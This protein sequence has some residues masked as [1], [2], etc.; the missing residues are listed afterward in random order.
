MIIEPDDRK[1]LDIQV[2]ELSDH[3]EHP[4]WQKLYEGHL[5]SRMSAIEPFL[6]YHAEQYCDIGGGLSGIS[7]LLNIY[8]AGKLHVNIIDGD[9][10]PVMLH[11]AIPFSSHERTITFLQNN[12]VSA[13][14][15][16]LPTR[17][18]VQV[19][20][21]I[22]SFRAWCFHIEPHVYLE[23]VKAHLSRR[24]RLIVDV[25]KDH[26]DWLAQLKATFTSQQISDNGKGA[27]WQF[28]W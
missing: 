24:G 3:V 26:G 14:S 28:Q 9:T 12:G 13:V 16:W 5:W 10:R 20:D 21:L 11:H 17:L 18:P 7:V 27:L 22:T 23:W 4:D 15:V 19:F 2:G 8:Y 1:Y 6:P 25:R